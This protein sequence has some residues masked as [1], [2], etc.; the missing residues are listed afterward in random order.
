[1]PTL[2]EQ[3]INRAVVRQVIRTERVAQASRIPSRPKVHGWFPARTPD[4]VAG[5]SAKV[6]H[7]CTQVSFRPGSDRTG[8]L[9]AGRRPESLHPINGTRSQLDNPGRTRLTDN[10]ADRQAP[11]E[12][13]NILP[14]NPCG[15]RRP[16]TAEGFD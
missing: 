3:P 9:G 6:A 7:L 1:M 4:A 16:N 15:F 5:Q 8:G 10:G 13:V 12:Q 2:S 11:A 14:V